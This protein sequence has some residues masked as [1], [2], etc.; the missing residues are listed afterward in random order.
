MFY[1]WTFAAIFCL[2]TLI[3]SCSGPVT[4]ENGYEICGPLPNQNV[5][6]PIDLQAMLVCNYKSNDSLPYDTHIG[7]L[8][9]KQ[10]CLL[11]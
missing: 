8:K 1:L 6:V 5:V 11:K 3:D 2:Y 10:T 7:L 9:E 4:S